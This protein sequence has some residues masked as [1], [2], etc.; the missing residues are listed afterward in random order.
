LFLRAKEISAGI[1]FI[2]SH[3][4]EVVANL[5]AEGNVSKNDHKRVSDLK[6]RKG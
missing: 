4:K 5:K 2:L 1:Y 6:E 3:Q